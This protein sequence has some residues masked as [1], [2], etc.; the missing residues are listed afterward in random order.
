MMTWVIR[1]IR[2]MMMRMS[3][4]AY[5]RVREWQGLYKNARVAEF[6]NAGGAGFI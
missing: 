4:R 5:V 6:R 2:K 3:G 1:V